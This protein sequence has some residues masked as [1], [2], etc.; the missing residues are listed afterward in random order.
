MF[1]LFRKN[2]KT[3]QSVTKRLAKR[4]LGLKPLC[5]SGC[6]Q[7]VTWQHATQDPNIYPNNGA[8]TLLLHSLEDMKL[9]L[10]P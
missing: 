2:E 7:V 8:M 9:C 5:Q 10:P 6:E 4:G 3:P 1:Q